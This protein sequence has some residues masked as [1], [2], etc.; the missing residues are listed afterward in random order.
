MPG[1]ASGIVQNTSTLVNITVMDVND[2]APR[3][4]QGLSCIFCVST[5][6]VCLNIHVHVNENLLMSVNAH[7]CMYVWVCKSMC[8]YMYIVYHEYMYMYMYACNCLHLT[9]VLGFWK[10]QDPLGLLFIL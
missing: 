4:L 10:H 7:I 2:N 1:H 6:R 8:T 5:V 3:F 9:M